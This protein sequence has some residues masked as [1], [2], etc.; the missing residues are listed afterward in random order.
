MGRVLLNL[1]ANAQRHGAPP[2]EVS[3]SMVGERRL[4]IEVS[5]EGPSERLVTSRLCA[6]LLCLVHINGLLFTEIWVIHLLQ[7]G[8]ANQCLLFGTLFNID[9]GDIPRPV[10]DVTFDVTIWKEMNDQVAPSAA[11][12]RM[13]DL[14]FTFTPSATRRSASFIVFVISAAEG[15]IGLHI[16]DAKPPNLKS[17]RGGPAVIPGQNCASG[18][19]LPLRLIARNCAPAMS[20]C[21]KDNIIFIGRQN[22]NIIYIMICVI[23]SS[24]A[25]HLEIGVTPFIQ[26]ARSQ[27]F[28]FYHLTAPS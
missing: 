17:L 20:L 21:R 9:S 8:A 4:C 10:I 2:I 15:H 18:R 7:A 27:A 23:I 22:E 13:L 19:Q 6:T 3:T 1:I 11:E 5:D 14:D 25:Y 16:D 28:N 12:R 24:L 26:I